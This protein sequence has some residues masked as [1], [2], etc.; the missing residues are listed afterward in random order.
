MLL[1]IKWIIFLFY[2]NSSV[3]TFPASHFLLATLSSD[4]M[5]EQLNNE[6]I[7]WSNGMWSSK[8][9]A[10]AKIISLMLV[11]NI[12][13]RNGVN[14]YKQHTCHLPN[15][16]FFAQINH[17]QGKGLEKCFQLCSWLV[18][19][20]RQDN[21]IFNPDLMA[22][23]S[24]VLRTVRCS[25]QSSSFLLSWDSSMSWIRKPYQRSGNV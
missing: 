25:R 12:L 4:W 19:A 1:L 2:L 6:L 24:M 10:A 15:S 8:W 14:K 5:N 21:S 17:A 20:G 3:D 22:W 23:G 18:L 11:L 16:N 7:T 9:A 13:Q